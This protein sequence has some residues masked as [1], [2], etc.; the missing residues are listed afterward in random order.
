MDDYIVRATASGNKATI[1]KDVGVG[2]I[3][4]QAALFETKKGATIKVL[5]SSVATRRPA[6]CAYSIYGT[7]GFLE[8]GRTGYDNIGL[9]YFEGIDGKN[10]RQIAVSSSDIDA[11]KK[12]LLGGHGTSEFSLVHDFLDAIERNTRPPIDYVKAMDMTVPG[13]IAHE[14]AMKGGVWL[15]VPRLI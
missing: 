13:L 10:G 11:P 14:A 9:R 1:I 5:R 12:A 2:A 4:M 7:K 6:V 15:D 8:T 3:D